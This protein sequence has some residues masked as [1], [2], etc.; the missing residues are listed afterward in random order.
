MGDRTL[1]LSV[2][3]E[4]A[5]KLL[6]GD[7]TVELRRVL[8]QRIERGDIVLLYATAPKA[9]FVGYCRVA[10]ILHDSPTALWPRVE[11]SAGVTRA[12]YFGYFRT[13]TRA[14][15]IVVE[16][17]V[18]FSGGISLDESR[19]YLPGFMPPRSFRYLSGLDQ[20]LR[21]ALNAA[22]NRSMAEAEQ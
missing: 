22:V 3:P 9:V 1:M 18:E 5:E 6:R 13:A 19:K 2:K 7:K 11:G 20:R 4:Y 8:P 21:D 16:S 14:I 10:D 17:P 12:E 15:G